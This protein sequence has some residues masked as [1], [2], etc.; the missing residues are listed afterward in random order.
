MIRMLTCTG[1]A[2]PLVARAR[3]PVCPS[4]A[5]RL[6]QP[7]GKKVDECP[8]IGVVKYYYS[9]IIVSAKSVRYAE[10]Q[11]VRYISR[12]CLYGE[13]IHVR[14]IVGCSTVLIYC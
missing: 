11:V 4:L 1:G 10:S 2:R 5:T 7:G 12:D 6:Q 14:Y 8:L 9:T 3:A 13:T